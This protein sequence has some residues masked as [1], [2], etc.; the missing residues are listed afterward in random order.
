MTEAVSMVKNQENR[1]L[2]Q[3][4]VLQCCTGLVNLQPIYL[5]DFSMK[6]CILSKTEVKNLALNKSTKD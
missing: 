1:H 4:T 5:E 3:G 6:E 2:K